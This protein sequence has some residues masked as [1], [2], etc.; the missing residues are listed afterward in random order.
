VVGAAL[1]A[2]GVA[3]ERNS[4]DQHSESPAAVTTV[5]SSVR[6]SSGSTQN[7]PVLWLSQCCSR[8][9]SQSS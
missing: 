7:H 6:R 3:V 4:G 1:F 9:P 5:L 2:V 8:S